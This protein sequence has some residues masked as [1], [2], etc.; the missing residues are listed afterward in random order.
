M[1][2]FLKDEIKLLERLVRLPENITKENGKSRNHDPNLHHRLGV[3]R[4]CFLE[5]TSIITSGDSE[6]AGKKLYIGKFAHSPK[7]INDIC[8]QGFRQALVSGCITNAIMTLT[9]AFGS[10]F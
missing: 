10:F 2:P 7:N 5:G 4:L 3:L 9:N 8:G 6:G 1:S